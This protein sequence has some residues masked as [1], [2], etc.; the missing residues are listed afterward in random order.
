MEG[1]IEGRRGVAS[2]ET[3]QKKRILVICMHRRT[4][5]FH[6]VPRGVLP[7]HLSEM[8]M[9]NVGMD[10]QICQVHVSYR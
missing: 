4:W 10:M 7:M 2:T 3:P 1:D 8:G 5:G 6:M 9:G